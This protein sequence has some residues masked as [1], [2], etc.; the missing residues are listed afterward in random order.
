MRLLSL[1][2]ASEC[3]QAASPPPLGV[4]QPC[5]VSFSSLYYHTDRNTDKK[6]TEQAADPLLGPFWI[7]T[8]L[9]V[10]L[11]VEG[12][13]RRSTSVSKTSI[14][15]GWMRVIF[16][17][18]PTGL[19]PWQKRLHPKKTAMILCEEN[20]YVKFGSVCGGARAH[21]YC[22]SPSMKMRINTK[23][24]ILINSCFYFL[25][26]LFIFYFLVG[27]NHKMNQNQVSLCCCINFLIY[28]A[29]KILKA[30]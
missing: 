9:F 14:K 12:R 21:R 24:Y 2:R 22:W 23:T 13:N 7:N 19:W 30:A 11:E 28:S 17:F 15:R 5:S 26:H 18:L 6:Q 20:A 3:A 27:I 25:L 4:V 16:H 8:V 10:M 29:A 1:L